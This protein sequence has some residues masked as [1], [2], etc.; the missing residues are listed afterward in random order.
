VRAF[1][2]SAQLWKDQDE[3][4]LRAAHKFAWEFEKWSFGSEEHN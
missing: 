4:Y 1:K 2:D 3:F